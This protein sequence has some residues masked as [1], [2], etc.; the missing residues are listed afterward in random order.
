MLSWFL[1]NAGRGTTKE[2]KKA[3]SPPSVA[4]KL[5]Q[6]PTASKQKKVCL[7]S[8]GGEEP[9]VEGQNGS[10]D[11]SSAKAASRRTES[12]PQALESFQPGQVTLASCPSNMVS[13]LLS[14][15]R[16]PRNDDNL[17]PWEPPLPAKD[18]GS[19]ENANN[20]V[21]SS[22]Q[23]APS[24]KRQRTRTIEVSLPLEAELV[25][26]EKLMVP[27]DDLATKSYR[28]RVQPIA[29]EQ[30]FHDISW[31][32]LVSQDKTRKG[33]QK[34]QPLLIPMLLRKGYPN[35]VRYEHVENASQ[36][37][38]HYEI[39]P[40][41]FY[42]GRNPKDARVTVALQHVLFA[43]N[44]ILAEPIMDSNMDDNHT[45]ANT[46][47]DMDKSSHCDHDFDYH[48]HEWYPND[49]FEAILNPT[50]QELAWL[51]EEFRHCNSAHNKDPS[52]LLWDFVW[53]YASPALKADLRSF[54]DDADQA[55]LDAL[56][57]KDPIVAK[58]MQLVQSRIAQLLQGGF[59]RLQMKRVIAILRLKNRS[60]KTNAARIEYPAPDF[61]AASSLR[62][63]YV[64]HA[65]VL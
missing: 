1:S 40:K 5:H 21:E 64:P 15:K 55:K 13:P 11:S 54:E 33:Y 9:I 56:I 39:N 23:Q 45:A 7:G 30:A 2:S 31:A 6:E 58:R 28:D 16:G 18:H 32:S 3:N 34:Q 10:S 35:P 37:A 36:E 29:A 22:T 14:H 47:G 26:H 49:P 12:V 38:E 8:N 42:S 27:L 57:R 63:Q 62:Y 20:G 17:V 44:S 25:L 48:L 19:H 59:R 61:A 43:G 65:V 51:F 52:N 24:R 60:R 50:E 41:R 53:E 4:L 46:N